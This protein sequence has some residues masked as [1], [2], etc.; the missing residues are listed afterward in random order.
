MKTPLLPDE[1]IGRKITAITGA[2]SESE[3]A[4]THTC[5]AL[6]LVRL[7]AGPR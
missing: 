4:G 1:R 5:A 6:L 3:S 7:E 2:I